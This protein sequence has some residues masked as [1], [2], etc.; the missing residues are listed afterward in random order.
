MKLIME[1]MMFKSRTTETL[2]RM[3]VEQQISSAFYNMVDNTTLSYDN[4]RDRLL[5]QFEDEQE[6]IDNLINEEI[7]DSQSQHTKGTQSL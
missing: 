5:D 7:C 6:F 3:Q 2:Q 4:I 1:K